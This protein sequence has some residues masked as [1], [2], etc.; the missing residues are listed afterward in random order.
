MN[1]DQALIRAFQ[2]QRIPLPIR[3][4]ALAEKLG[5]ELLDVD[6][7]SGVAR[8]GFRPDSFF[9]QAVNV[10]QGGAIAAML[11]FALAFAVLAH[12]PDGYSAASASLTVCFIRPVR[13]ERLVATGA[14]DRVGKNCAFAR[15]TL[16][17]EDDTLLATATSPL[18]VIAPK[19]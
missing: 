16:A 1:P 4:S 11:D 17:L 8:L 10:V 6:D 14:V 12:M 2:S 19:A 7:K 3:T 18:S 15:A 9:C 5:A 13:P